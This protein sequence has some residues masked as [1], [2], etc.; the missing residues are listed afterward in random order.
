MSEF[1]RTSEKVVKKYVEP[2]GRITSKTLVALR[3]QQ[4]PPAESL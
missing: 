3:D 1:W 2:D 4:E